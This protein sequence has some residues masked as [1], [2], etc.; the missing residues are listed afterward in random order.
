M[1]ACP[2]LLTVGNEALAHDRIDVVSLAVGA[3][4]T[5]EEIAMTLLAPYVSTEEPSGEYV[6]TCD[7]M[8]SVNVVPELSF[9]L[10]RL[11]A[12]DATAGI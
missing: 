10:Q 5:D 11:T 12:V 2:A 7:A 6:S 1:R 9:I 3:K 8:L 4:S